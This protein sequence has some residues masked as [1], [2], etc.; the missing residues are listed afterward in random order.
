MKVTLPP[1]QM[2]GVLGVAV[3][4]P[5]GSETTSRAG[6]DEAALPQALAAVTL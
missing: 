3:T 1:T 5:I 2:P 4:A 6:V